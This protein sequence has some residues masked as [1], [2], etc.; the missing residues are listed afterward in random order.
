MS[1][2]WY[3]FSIKGYKATLESC[4]KDED[5][6]DMVENWSDRHV[7]IKADSLVYAKTKLY[8]ICSIRNKDI[9]VLDMNGIR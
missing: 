6:I 3:Y 8:T 4:D 9:I 7:H 2:K 5:V 1:D